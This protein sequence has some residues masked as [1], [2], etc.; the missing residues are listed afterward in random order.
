M[1]LEEIERLKLREEG[2]GKSG[3]Q[4]KGEGGLKK[5]GNTGRKWDKHQEGKMG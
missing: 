2:M 5:A 1:R 3:G 4:C